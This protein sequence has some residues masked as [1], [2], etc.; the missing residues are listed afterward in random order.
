MSISWDTV[1]SADTMSTFNSLTDVYVALHDAL[2]GHVVDFDGLLTDGAWLERDFC[3]TGSFDIVCDDVA[4]WDR[5]VLSLSELSAVD[6]Q[7]DVAFVRIVEQLL[8]DVSHILAFRGGGRGMTSPHSSLL[9]P[10]TLTCV[11]SLHLALWLTDLACSA[12]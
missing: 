11:W 9:F 1:P 8:L 10:K 4:F 6:L 7:H 3:A 5:L 2:E 12:L